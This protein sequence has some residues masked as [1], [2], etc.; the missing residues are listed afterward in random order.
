MTDS[1]ATPSFD[2]G[3][4]SDAIDQRRGAMFP[5][6]KNLHC[7]KEF[8]AANSINWRVFNNL[9]HQGI[10]EKHT[11]RVPKSELAARKREKSSRKS[12]VLF[13]FPT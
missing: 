3:Q 4:R 8:W 13:E 1:T 6:L 2:D 11:K 5:Y 12:L 7:W 10:R 9:K